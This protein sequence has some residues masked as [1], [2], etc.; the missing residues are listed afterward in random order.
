MVKYSDLTDTQKEAVTSPNSQLR[1]IAGAGSGKTRVLTMRIVHLIENMG[2]DPRRILA[3]TFTNKAAAEMKTR[4][5]EMLSEDLQK[6]TISTIHSFCVLVLR[7]EIDAIGYPKNFTICD[8]QDQETI[9]KDVYKKLDLTRDQL[10]F[11]AALDHIGNCKAASVDPERDLFLASGDYIQ[12]KAALVYKYYEEYL[13][14]NYIL[15]FDDLILKV[16]LI[17]NKFSNVRDKWANRY[18][19]VLVDEFQDIDPQQYELIKHLTSVHHHVY[20]VGDPDQTI[21]TW[22]GA[23]VDIILNFEK[24]F[25]ETKTIVLNENFRSTKNILEGS[26]SII[27]NNQKRIKKDL[28]TNN[29]EGSKIIRSSFTTE[30]YECEFVASQI[31]SLIQSNNYQYNDIAILYRSNFQSRA[32]EKACILNRIPYMVF[33]G[34]KF[35]ERAEVKDTLAYLKMLVTA[36]N[37]AFKRS[38][39]QPK[40][41]VGNATIDRI[42]EL[43]EKD[44]IT[45]YEAAVKYESEINSKGLSQYLTIIKNLKAFGTSFDEPEDLL[46]KVLDYSGLR[47]MYEADNEIE[48]LENVKSLIDDMAV[49]KENYPESNLDEYLQMVN[50]YTDKESQNLESAIKLMTVH[51]AKGLEFKVVFVIGMNEGYFPNARAATDMAG[52]EE[53]R[54][55]AYVA[56][57][58]AREKLYITEN[59]SYDFNT[60]ISRTSSRFLREL[61]EQ[62]VN[63]LNKQEENRRTNVQSGIFDVPIINK[64]VVKTPYK[65][66]DVIIHK[67]FGEGVI[68]SIK[69]GIG[70]IMFDAVGTKKLKLD[71]PSISKKETKAAAESDSSVEYFIDDLPSSNKKEEVK[72]IIIPDK[73]EPV[74]TKGQQIHH[75]DYGMGVVIRV[76]DASIQVAFSHPYGLMTLSINDP[77]IK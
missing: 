1:V 49:F 70:E 25:K 16:L 38:V 22:R 73:K 21:Y 11:A 40:R 59:S 30:D 41:K 36:D 52:V 7:Q 19:E 26:N 68:K 76:S 46:T 75:E 63:N 14:K 8:R 74:F 9:L 15:D 55:L 64:T 10:S 35:F 56:F 27:K 44:N 67:L 69:D 32:M 62:Y 66:N 51:A 24:D 65:K 4:I 34:I 5:N 33:G 47:A 77:K 45:L 20:V 72:E 61:D 54:R 60:G 71:H 13:N 31:E 6:S 39:N 2:V 58:R 42:D 57:T 50:L 37:L 53:E 29:P 43:A 3:I 12:E 23:S 17:F 48:R 18:Q 28:Y